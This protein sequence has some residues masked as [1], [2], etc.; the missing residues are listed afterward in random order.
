MAT[1]TIKDLVES[2][3]L[4]SKAMAA[5]VGG[6]GS[7]EELAARFPFILN[8][9]SVS[10]SFPVSNETRQWAEAY[11]HVGDFNFGNV[12]QSNNQVQVAGQVGNILG[13]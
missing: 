11:N 8:L 10:T 4:D 9:T 3:E 5:V 2:K 13:G 7:M 1:L 12:N 6:M